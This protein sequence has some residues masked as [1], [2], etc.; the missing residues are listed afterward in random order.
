MVSK[1]K[2]RG[3]GVSLR[4]GAA[5]ITASQEGQ[6]CRGIS[7]AAANTASGEGKPRAYLKGRTTLIM[8]RKTRCFSEGR[9][10]HFIRGETTRASLEG[11]DHTATEE[12]QPGVT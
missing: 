9:N 7:E 12:G 5:V 2:R 3:P 10:Q 11:S 6:P 1:E 4:V 8:T